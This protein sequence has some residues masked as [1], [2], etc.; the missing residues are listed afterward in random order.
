MSSSHVSD[1]KDD[2][3][4]AAPI[5]PHSDKMLEMLSYFVSAAVGPSLPFPSVALIQIQCR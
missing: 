5:L 4:L 1:T 3:L 2:V